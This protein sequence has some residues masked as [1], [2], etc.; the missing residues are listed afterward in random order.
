MTNASSMTPL[1]ARM[2]EQMQIGS[3]APATQKHY[4][5]TISILARDTGTAPDQLDAERVRSWLVNQIN[6]GLTPAST[7]TY[8]SALRFLYQEVLDRPDMV[9]SLRNRKRPRHLP[10]HMKEDEIE[11]LLLATFDLRYRTAILITY[12]A[13]LRISET[14]A[15]QIADIKAGKKLLHI[16]SGKGNVER[17]APLPVPVIEYLRTFWQNTWPR[18]ATWLFYGKSPDIPIKEATLRRAF[19]E[20]RERAGI[21]RSV[22]FHDL[23]HSAATHWHERGGDI[24]V[25]QDA[26]GHR[27]ADTTRTYARATGK[28]FEALDHPITGFRLLLTA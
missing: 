15:V 11:R 14:I 13:G 6:R 5:G 16:R 25:I 17:M 19:S 10:R 12:A 18:P 1:R 20:A 9:R 2:I 28:M 8:L 7:N 23:R 3:L 4:L 26:L 22:K 27:N 21:N 24:D